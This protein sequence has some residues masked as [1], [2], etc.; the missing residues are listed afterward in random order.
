MKT[1]TI[2]KEVIESLRKEVEEEVRK[3]IKEEMKKRYLDVL[4][5]STKGTIKSQVHAMPPEKKKRVRIDPDTQF[6]MKSYDNTK[7]FI[8]SL[9]EEKHDWQ[10]TGK[11]LRYMSNKRCILCQKSYNKKKAEITSIITAPG[12]FTE[13]QVEKLEKLCNVDKKVQYLGALCSNK[14]NYSG[15]GLSLRN[16]ANKRCVTCTELKTGKK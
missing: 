2:T 3:E 7:F 8:G 10:G 11:S 1:R 12:D 5:S 4:F 13:S 16:K 9:C 15:S 6:G 14:H